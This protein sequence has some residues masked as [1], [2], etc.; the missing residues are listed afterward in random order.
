MVNHNRAARRQLHCAGVGRFNLVFDLKAAKQRRVIAVA[1]DAGRMFRH[2]VGH[3]LLR[4]FVHIVGVNQD[5]A[6]IA[7]EIVANGTNHQARFLVNQISTLAAFGCAIDGVP[8]FEQV[9]QVPLQFWGAA[10][11][12]CGTRNDAHAVGVFELIKCFFELGAVIAFD[13]AADTTTTRVVRHQNDVTTSKRDEG[14]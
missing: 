13:A 1:F 6:N 11:D 3:E 12:P 2:H 7:I 9:V 14:G 8:K 4:L 10:S 5:V